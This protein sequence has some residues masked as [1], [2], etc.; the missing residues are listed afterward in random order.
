MA[1]EV[2]N[3]DRPGAASAARPLTTES[4]R[5]DGADARKRDDQQTVSVKALGIF[6]KDGGLDGERVNPGDTFDCSRSRAAELRA[7]GLVEYTN[8]SD[9]KDIHGDDAERLSQRAKQRMEQGQIRDKD[10]GTPLKNPTV[11]GM[12]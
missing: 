11:P 3:N 2:K 8:E 12:D 7:N 4:M 9:E 10:K 6:H 1:D 5:N